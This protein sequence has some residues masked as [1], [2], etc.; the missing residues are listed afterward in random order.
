MTPRNEVDAL[1]STIYEELRR[2]AYAVKREREAPTL[3]PTALVHEAWLKLAASPQTVMTSPLHFKRIAARAM[4][5]VLVDAARRRNAGKRGG[6]VLPLAFDEAS[7]QSLSS[8]KPAVS[9]E[10]ALA[11]DQV[12]EKLQQ[13][14]PRKASVFEAQF[15]GGM[16]D[17]EVA[18][19]LGISE[20]TVA[21]DWR[22]A[23]AWVGY[24][25]RL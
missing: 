10:Q 2:L 14:E 3:N 19:I 1:F 20:E 5:Q 17:A 21:R 25:M 23:K 8:A 12:L 9:L 22:E 24:R 16:T 11:L 13:L 4:R 7:E 6:S 15:F 18:E